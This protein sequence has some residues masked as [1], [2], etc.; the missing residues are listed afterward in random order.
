MI[1]SPA[2]VDL[3]SVLEL[4]FKLDASDKAALVNELVQSAGLS[5]VITDQLN[6][7]VCTCVDSLDDSGKAD[8]LHAIAESL[9]DR[10]Y[11]TS[12]LKKPS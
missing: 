8:V 5:V 12:R 7:C 6:Q 4:A 2:S 11:S 9:R 3:Q 10:T 1:P